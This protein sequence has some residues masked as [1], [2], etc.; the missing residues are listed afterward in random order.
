M[1]PGCRSRWWGV[2]HGIAPNQLFRWRR[3][4][5]EGALSAMYAGEEAIR[6]LWVFDAIPI[7]ADRRFGNA[8]IGRAREGQHKCLRHRL[9][10]DCADASGILLPGLDQQFVMQRDNKKGIKALQAVGIP[11]QAKEQ[12]SEDEID[13]RMYLYGGDPE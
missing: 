1:R 13:D 9:L 3:L 10:K 6:L 11:V 2:G 8:V 7:R 4:Y 5:A 12:F